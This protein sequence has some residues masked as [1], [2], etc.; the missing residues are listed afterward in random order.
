M[1]RRR[2]PELRLG[3]PRNPCLFVTLCLFA[4]SVAYRLAMGSIGPGLAILVLSLLGSL[5][6]LLLVTTGKK[7][8]RVSPTRLRYQGSEIEWQDVESITPPGE[9]GEVVLTLRRALPEPLA[10]RTGWAC[11][12][13][14]VAEPALVLFGDDF[15]AGPQGLH[16][17]LTAIHAEAR[18]AD[19]SPRTADVIPS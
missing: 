18:A 19:K 7:E 12:S 16:F 3:P 1:G 9:N 4:A 2:E 17:A 11:R 15:E 13:F 14:G 8:L 6:V 5:L 10:E